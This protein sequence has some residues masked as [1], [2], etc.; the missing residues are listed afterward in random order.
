[1]FRR[2]CNLADVGKKCNVGGH[3]SI[4]SQRTESQAQP[5]GGG[6]GIVIMG[7]TQFGNLVT[8]KKQF[9]EFARIRSRS[10]DAPTIAT[11]RRARHD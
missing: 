7:D 1:M 4:H 6:G 5:G 8:H 3:G 9:L 11:L 2:H 10:E